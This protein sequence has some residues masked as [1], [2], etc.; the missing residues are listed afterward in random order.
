MRMRQDG[1]LCADPSDPK[2]FRMAP[3]AS[4][5]GHHKVYLWNGKLP[6]GLEWC[7]KPRGNR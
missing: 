3:N 5:H 7:D 2:G 1:V 6:A 4:G